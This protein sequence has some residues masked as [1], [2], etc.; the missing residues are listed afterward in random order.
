MDLDAKLRFGGSFGLRLS[1][2]DYFSMK[3]VYMDGVFDLFHIGHIRDVPVADIPGDL[4]RC[5]LGAPTV[6]GLRRLR[7]ILGALLSDTPRM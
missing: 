5:T 3:V 1:S 4:V 2:T 7:K 6:Q